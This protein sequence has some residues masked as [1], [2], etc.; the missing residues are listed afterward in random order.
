MKQYTLIGGNGFIG[1]EIYK[2]LD[3]RNC[4]VFVAP[5]NDSIVFEKD[6]G[7]VIYCAGHGDCL[8]NPNK[9]FD[10]NT[11][12]LKKIIDSAMFS[13]M[14]YISSTRVYMG[15]EEKNVSEDSDVVIIKKDK[16]RLFNLTKLLSEELCFSSNRDIV[17]VRP[18]NVY[19]LAIKSPLFLPSIIRDA[20]NNGVVD[21]YVTPEYRK[22]YV[23]VYDV[24]KIIYE[25]ATRDSLKSNLYNI[26][27]GEN[28]SAREIADILQKETMCDVVWHS[29]GNDE[30]FPI[31]DISKIKTEFNFVPSKVTED[32]KAMIE[33]FVNK[34]NT[35]I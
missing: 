4:S 33:D 9:V 31:N 28:T 16:R 25:I 19:G 14:I 24:A 13:R 12:Y 34:N 35:E 18:S 3:E 29:V 1:S 23:S 5:K 2:Y 8:N 6:L 30:I 15:T 22:D 27:A 21:M 7:T 26:A 10:S 11:S 32:L 17:V 20:I